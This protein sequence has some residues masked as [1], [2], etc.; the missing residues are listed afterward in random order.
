M[1]KMNSIRVKQGLEGPREDPYGFTEITFWHRGGKTAVHAG[2]LVEWVEH[3]GRRWDGP[4]VR[5]SFAAIV[6]ISSDRLLKIHA[7][8]PWR[9]H[10]AKCPERRDFHCSPGMPGETLT[11][12]GRCRDVVRCD[13]NIGEVI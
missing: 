13:F 12:C 10:H 5:A 4:D 2:G 11:I 8:L 6:G 7:E 3:N 1:A 9:R